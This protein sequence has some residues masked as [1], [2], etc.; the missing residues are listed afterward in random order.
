MINGETEASSSATM[1]DHACRH[2]DDIIGCVLM[3]LSVVILIT[4]SVVFLVTMLHGLSVH[5]SLCFLLPHSRLVSPAFL[6]DVLF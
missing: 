2:I 5:C 4:L 3:T 6:S 1:A